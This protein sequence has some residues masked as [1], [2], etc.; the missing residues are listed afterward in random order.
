M[1]YN[2]HYLK[3]QEKKVPSLQIY[4]WLRLWLQ[5]TK[6]EELDR[7]RGGK[8]HFCEGRTQSVNE[9]KESMN[10]KSKNKSSHSNN[11]KDERIINWVSDALTGR[12]LLMTLRQVVCLR[13]VHQACQGDSQM[14]PQTPDDDQIGVSQ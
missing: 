6:N 7:K 4:G 10:S 13:S 12:S 5:N 3:L 11:Q 14:P 1:G 8:E 2:I 9:E